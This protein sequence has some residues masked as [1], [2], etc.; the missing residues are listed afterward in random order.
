[1]SLGSK[2]KEAATSAGKDAGRAVVASLVGAMVSG[3]ITALK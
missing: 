2:M 1:M 3:A